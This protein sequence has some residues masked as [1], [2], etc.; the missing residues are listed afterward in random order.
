MELTSGS[1][2][3][4][5]LLVAVLVTLVFVVALLLRNTIANQ[6]LSAP[7]LEYIETKAEARAKEIIDAAEAE[8]DK[9]LAA[10]AGEAVEIRRLHEEKVTQVMEELIAGMQERGTSFQELAQR[11]LSEQVNLLEGVTEET[12]TKVA[13]LQTTIAAE[14]A[15][16]QAA[17][18]DMTASLTKTS[19]DVRQSL[20][21]KVEAA[22]AAFASKLDSYDQQLAETV[23]K[24]TARMLEAINHDMEGYREQ[25]QA[26]LDA[27]IAQ[28]VEQVTKQVLH[29]QLTVAEHAELAKQALASVKR[30]EVL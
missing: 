19:Q 28:I 4:V 14:E 16:V 27:H 30:N 13:Q 21:H 25:R 24:E 9:R 11:A 22:A 3:V 5:T 8:A 17:T 6:K 7:V 15:A 10:V 18:K 26:M 2:A 20:E 23:T 1:F 29:K 12:R